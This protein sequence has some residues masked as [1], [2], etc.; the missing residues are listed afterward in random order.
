MSSEK[1]PQ[2][3]ARYK[4]AG[5]DCGMDAAHDG[6]WV[7]YPDHEATIEAL[8]AERDIWR[9]HTEAAI[10]DYQAEK[11]KRE[12]AEAKLARAREA[13]E[14]FARHIDEM[15]FDID[16]RGNELPDDQAVGWVYVT[17]GDFRRARALLSDGGE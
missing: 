5:Y 1:K 6:G 14:P 9:G 10:D 7:R 3:V 13:L 2:P 15:K 4:E 17:I 8:R 11:A 12:A 16:N